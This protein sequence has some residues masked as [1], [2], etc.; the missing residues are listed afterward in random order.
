[1]S[2]KPDQQMQCRYLKS[3]GHPCRGAAMRGQPYCYSHGRDLRRYAATRHVA[4]IQIPLL[5]NCADIQQF[6]TDVARALVVASIDPPMARILLHAARMAST[7]LVRE[8]APRRNKEKEKEAA[9]QLLPVEEVFP[10][11]HGLDLA[12]E[13]PYNSEQN[14]PERRWSLSEYLFRA[15]HPEKADEP[16]PEEG[17]MTRPKDGLGSAAKPAAPQVPPSNPEPPDPSTAPPA[18]SASPTAML[19]PE[20]AAPPVQPQSL[21]PIIPDPA[22]SASEPSP[23]EIVLNTVHAVP[24]TDSTSV[25]SRPNA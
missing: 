20:T 24:A 18:T 11:P 9:P 3:S 19:Q 7:L 1:M 22:L 10:G 25:P 21:H 17:Y 14:K 16:L 15:M 8:A 6:I 5:D 23:S 12:P 4:A 13:T 2:E